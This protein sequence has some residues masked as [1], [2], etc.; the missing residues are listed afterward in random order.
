LSKVRASTIRRAAAVAPI[1][2]VEVEA[3]LSIWEI[4]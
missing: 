4:K 1:A 3:E 2:A